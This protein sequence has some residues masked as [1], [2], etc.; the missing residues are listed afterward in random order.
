MKKKKKE[1]SGILY[2]CLIII[3]VLICLVGIFDYMVYDELNKEK[4]ETSTITTNNIIDP[5]QTIIAKNDKIIINNNVLCINN[6]CSTEKTLGNNKIEYKNNKYYINNNEL[7]INQTIKEIS[8]VD[9]TDTSKYLL[10]RLV[11]DNY[12]IYNI[13]NNTIT[14]IN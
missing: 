13:S 4:K 2:V 3:L 9:S 12:V 6:N 14:N 5:I 7:N 10:I 1:T 8:V 11:D